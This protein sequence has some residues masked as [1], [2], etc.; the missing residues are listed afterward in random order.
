MR[1]ADSDIAS[2]GNRQTKEYYSFVRGV[3]LGLDRKI[4]LK[5]QITATPFA[6]H[7]TKL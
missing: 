5:Q 3:Q 4:D 7:V 6:L 2:N 1:S